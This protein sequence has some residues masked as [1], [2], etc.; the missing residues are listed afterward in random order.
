MQELLRRTRREKLKQIRR[1]DVS[2]VAEEVSVT[3][4]LAAEESASSGV[5]AEAPQ[6]ATA[7]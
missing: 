6:T 3:H 7:S 1:C 4:A 5:P 2:L